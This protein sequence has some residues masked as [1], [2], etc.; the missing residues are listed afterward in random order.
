M[1]EKQIQCNIFSYIYIHANSLWNS[2]INSL[3]DGDVQVAIIGLDAFTSK[4]LR[5]M[6]HFKSSFKKIPK[7]TKHKLKLINNNI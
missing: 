4:L 2:H 7:K 5:F 6:A 3:V 1:M